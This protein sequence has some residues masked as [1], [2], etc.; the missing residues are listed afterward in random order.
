MTEILDT[1]VKL[2]QSDIWYLT[3]WWL[4]V[5]GLFLF[6]IPWMFLK[7]TFV[8]LPLW[9]PI[10]LIAACFKRSKN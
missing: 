6:Y 7:W 1:L 9:L 3:Q 4:W 8:T 10:G 2:W 5:F